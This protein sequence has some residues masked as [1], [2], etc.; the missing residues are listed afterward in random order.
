MKTF[1]SAKIQ[2]ATVT[3]AKLHYEGSI[4]IDAELMKRCGI[5]PY[6][7]VHVLN[8]TNGE[9]IITYAIEGEKG[10]ICLNGAAARLF[11]IGDKVIIIAYEQ[12]NHLVKPTILLMNDDNSVSKV[13]I[14]ANEDIRERWSKDVNDL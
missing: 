2:N 1:C 6:E 4:T 8:V 10:Q 7:Q 5:V 12:S 13:L 11:L 3:E 14:G 9:R